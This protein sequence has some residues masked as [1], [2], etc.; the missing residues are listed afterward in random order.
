MAHL[1]GF[2]GVQGNCSISVFV[3][4]NALGDTTIIGGKGIEVFNTIPE[5]SYV[6]LLLTRFILS[7]RNWPQGSG[8]G[9]TLAFVGSIIFI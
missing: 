8:R 2:C 1:S 7:P 3:L 9:Y 6:C 4:T 5:Y